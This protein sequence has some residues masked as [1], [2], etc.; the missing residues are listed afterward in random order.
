MNSLHEYLKE[1][2]ST[3]YTIKVLKFRDKISCGN[4]R[5]R[6]FSITVMENTS[7]KLSYRR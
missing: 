7:Y 2:F 4:G 6:A 1:I 3:Y 5:S